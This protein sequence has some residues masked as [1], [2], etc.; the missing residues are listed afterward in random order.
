M[1]PA[2]EFLAVQKVEIFK[3]PKLMDCSGRRTECG[4]PDKDILTLRSL[5]TDRG[6]EFAVCEKLTANRYPST[7]A[8]RRGLRPV[9]VAPHSFVS[10]SKTSGAS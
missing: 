2:N 4:V 8:R 6:Q 9:V 3:R 7:L 10:A 1:S 5:P